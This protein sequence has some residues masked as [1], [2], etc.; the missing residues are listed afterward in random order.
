MF[1]IFKLS[2]HLKKKK[3]NT[4]LFMLLYTTEFFLILFFLTPQTI[5]WCYL[6]TYLNA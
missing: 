4:L 2:L 6:L 1:F 5:L 3:K